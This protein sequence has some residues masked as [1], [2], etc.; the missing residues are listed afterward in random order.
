MFG[1]SGVYGN[2]SPS[3]VL[4]WERQTSDFFEAKRKS[5]VSFKGAKMVSV[6]GYGSS[7]RRVTV[8]TTIA[9]DGTKYIFLLFLRVNQMENL[10]KNLK[11]VSHFISKLLFWR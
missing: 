10:E 8:C 4:L 7:E 2:A 5:T 3:R 11:K 9:W 6:L 1:A